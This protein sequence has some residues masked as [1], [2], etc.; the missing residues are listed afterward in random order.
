[1]SD[2]EDV[3]YPIAHLAEKL[4]IIYEK[5]KRINKKIFIIL[6]HFYTFFHLSLGSQ[7]LASSSSVGK[8]YTLYELLPPV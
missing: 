4:K 6:L 3:S 1:M 8:R 5:N 2:I 7:R